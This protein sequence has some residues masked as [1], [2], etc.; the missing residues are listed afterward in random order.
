M[1]EKEE[2]GSSEWREDCLKWRCRV[3]TGTEAEGR[4]RNEKM[5]GET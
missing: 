3:L 4:E 5:K 1:S 2:F